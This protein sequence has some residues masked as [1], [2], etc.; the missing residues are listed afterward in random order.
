M[1]EGDGELTVRTYFYISK[2]VYLKKKNPTKVKK[3]MS[4]YCFNIKLSRHWSGAWI[5]YFGTFLT[6]HAK[7]KLSKLLIA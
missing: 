2:I 1:K 5:A 4:K 7:K 3:K 6:Q